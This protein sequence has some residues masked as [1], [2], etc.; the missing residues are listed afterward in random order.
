MEILRYTFW[1]S[2]QRWFERSG[3]WV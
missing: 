1:R 3:L 2:S